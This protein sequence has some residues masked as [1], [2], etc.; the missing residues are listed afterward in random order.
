MRLSQILRRDLPE[1]P[2]I[3]GVTSD[4]RR[5]GPGVLFAALPG[6]VRDGADFAPLAV[7]AG[8]ASVLCG[9]DLPGL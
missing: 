3:T 1:D 5:V 2:E 8:A 7:A 4:S 6:V 9:R